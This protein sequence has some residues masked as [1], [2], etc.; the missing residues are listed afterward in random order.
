M[1][2]AGLTTT[3]RVDAKTKLM[4]KT[5]KRETCGIEGKD[6]GVHTTQHSEP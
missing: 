3:K 1:T 5:V 4:N 2:S 6:W